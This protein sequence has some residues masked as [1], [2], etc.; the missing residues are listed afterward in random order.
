MAATPEIVVEPS[1]DLLAED[2]AGRVLSTLAAALS[3]RDVAHLVLTGGGILEKVMRAVRDHP[4]RDSIEWR[5]V[6]VWWGDERFVAAD[7]SE[8]ND[9]A[10]FAALLDALPL[11][12]ALVHRMPADGG[13]FGADVDAAAAGYA[14][15]LAD[16]ASPDAGEDDVPRFDVILLGI[17]PDGHCASLFPDQPGVH[18]Q[19]AAVIGVRNS[20][21]PPPTR[22]SLTFQALDAASE[23]WFIASGESKAHAVAMTLGG[24]DR[25]H[26]PSAGPRG[27]QRTL[28]LIDRDAAAELPGTLAG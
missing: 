4:G 13:A 16:A 28:W 7:S 26:V 20:P 2:T 12:P 10:A 18:E 9:V 23:V 25:T 1:A 19:A 14:R 27:R 6:H 5:R 17:G 21:K 8:R 22:M 24:A 3:A 15:L 11:D